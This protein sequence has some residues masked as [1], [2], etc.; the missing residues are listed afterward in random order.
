MAIELYMMIPVSWGISYV[1]GSMPFSYV[2]ARLKGV[3]LLEVGTRNPG[4]MNAWR[5]VHPLVGIAGG[6]GDVLKATAA[7]TIVITIAKTFDLD[8]RMKDLLVAGSAISVVIGHQKSLILRLLEGKWVGGKGFGCYAGV[9]IAFSWISFIILFIVLMGLLQIPKKIFKLKT[10]LF[11]NVIVAGTSLPTIWFMTRETLPVVILMLLIIL[12]FWADRTSLVNG[13]KQVV[14][15]FLERTAETYY[16]ED[17]DQPQLADK[18]D[19]SSGQQK[20]KE[21]IILNLDDL[22]EII[23]I[24]TKTLAE[25][26]SHVNMINVFPVPDGDTGTNLA[27]TLKKIQKHVSTLKQRLVRQPPREPC[28]ELRKGIIRSGRGNSGLI[29]TQWLEGVLSVCCF[30][31]A[32]QCHIK[33]SQE[34]IAVALQEGYLRARNAVTKPKEGTMLSVMRR[35]AEIHSNKNEQLSVAT[36]DQNLNQLSRKIEEEIIKSVKETVPK[37]EE[38]TGVPIADAGAVGFAIFM[39][40]ILT[41]LRRDSSIIQELSSL[42]DEWLQFDYLS[43]RLVPRILERSDSYCMQCTIESETLNLDELTKKLAALGDSL[44]V[45]RNPPSYRIHIHSDNPDQVLAVLFEGDYDITDIHIE[46]IKE[47]V[48]EQIKLRM[49]MTSQ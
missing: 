43:V 3:N 9:I 7:V 18:T 17:M 22:L 38:L 31:E 46:N 19:D 33:I 41:K 1:I 10:N 21:I 29:F 25:W 44:Q 23:D 36:D 48:Q 39:D 30:G 42:F 6:L 4:G 47:Q 24:A 32:T 40:S 8:P 28:Q 2:L 12:L 34:T 35:L 49:R 14:S 16:I 26:K 20:E 45:S 37:M 11:A 13:F 15:P 5:S 27:E